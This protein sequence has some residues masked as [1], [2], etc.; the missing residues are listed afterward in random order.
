MV[1]EWERE[2]PWEVTWTKKRELNKGKIGRML[3]LK[4]IVEEKEEDIEW[5]RRKLMDILMDKELKLVREGDD[6]DFRDQLFKG[7]KLGLLSFEK[8]EGKK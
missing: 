5:G 8:R 3:K 7:T 2:K 4:I 1:G 6:T